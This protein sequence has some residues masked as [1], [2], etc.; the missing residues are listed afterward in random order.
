KYGTIVRVA[1]HTLSISDPA[2]ISKIY[3]VS[4]KFYKSSFYE[5][6]EAHDEEGL[7][8]DTFV[9]KDKALH[10]RMK[11]NSSNA[12]SLN[13][14]LQV[15]PWLEPVNARVVKILDKHSK[16]G[17]ELD[18]GKMLRDF[19]M[20]AIFSITFGKDWNFL[21]EGDSLNLYPSLNS[22]V[23]YMAIVGQ[24]TWLHRHIFSH[25]WISQWFFGGADTGAALLEMSKLAAEEAERYR[26][27]PTSD[28]GSWTFLQRLI[29]NQQDNPKSITDRELNS[30]AFGN[31]SAGSDTT[32]VTLR[33]V[34]YHLLTNP[35][36]YDRLC[37]EIRRNLKRPVRFSEARE[38]KY[39]TA[40]IKEAMRIHPPIGMLLGRTVPPGGASI[41]GK[42]ISEGTEVGL[43]P[44]VLHHDPEVFEE[45]GKF[46]PQRWL[47]DDPDDQKLKAMNRSFFAFGAGAHTCSGR[48]ISIME[49]TK[50]I[51]E[52][53]LDHDF[54]LIDGGSTYTFRNL[55]L[56][57]QRGL[58]ATIKKRSS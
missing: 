9:L 36:T 23:D 30:H 42:Y 12:Y 18:L 48:H 54:E 1:P 32:S 46:K 52:M 33:A 7:I 35:V 50:L 37:E 11:R 17:L 14:L 51:P 49:T 25:K 20:D 3:G 40:V 28:S 8:P 10:S 24:C 44:W 45:P 41:C 58:R 56:S 55:W 29:M 13:G 5:I 43:S 15:E 4:T 34:F 2:E 6:A 31:I 16:S 22:D 53:L 47:S 21:E 38:L 26:Q 19:G 27:S 39:L 57:S